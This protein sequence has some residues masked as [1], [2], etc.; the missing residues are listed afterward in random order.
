MVRLEAS[1][2]EI[3][4]QKQWL[5]KLGMT[6]TEWIDRRRKGIAEGITLLATKRSQKAADLTFAGDVHAGAFTYSLTRQLWDMTEAPTVTTVMSATT[7]KTEQLLKTITNSR[8]QTPGWE[9]QA[10]GQ[11]EQELIYFTKPTAIPATAIVQQVA[12]NQVRVLLMNE[13]QSIEAFGKGATLTIG[14]NQGTIEIESRQQLIATGIVK[15]GKVTPGTPLQEN[16]RT[17]PKETSLKIGIDASLKSESAIVKQELSQLP[18]IEAVEL[19]TSEVHYILGRMTPKYQQQGRSTLPPINSIGLFSSGLEIVPES[20]STADETIE[21]AIDRLRSKLR[22]LLAARILKLMLNADASKLK[23]SAEIQSEGAVLV[24][25]AFTIRGEQSRKRTVPQLKI[26]QGFR[27]VVQ[28]QEVRDLYVAIILTSPEGN[29]YVASPQTD[30]AA[31]G[32]LKAREQMQLEVKRILPPVGAG[33]ALMI[34]STSPLKSAV[35]TLRSIASE[36]RNSADDLLD[37]LMLDRGATTSGISQV[38][39][40]DIA[41]LSMTFDIVE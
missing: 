18:R 17:I 31:A 34:A 8:T 22:S 4:Y 39:T 10:G 32:L 36:D 2:E 3:N 12:D 33:E 38:K 37:G 19:L 16:T 25:Q 23:V 41:A 26:G 9:K 1:Q 29:L 35:R 14:N 6:E 7:A 40:S 24:G 30:D 21:A 5:A 13:P 11:C 15:A 20:F 28:N 27:V